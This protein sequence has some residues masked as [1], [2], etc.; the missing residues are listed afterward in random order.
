MTYFPGLTD[1]QVVWSDEHNGERDSW[2]LTQ[3]QTHGRIGPRRVAFELRMSRKEAKAL[4]ASAVA[5]GVLRTDG[6]GWYRDAM[7]PA[8]Q[9]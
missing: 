2:L 3:A 9:G 5:R 6:D 4:L 8:G 1:V 7:Q